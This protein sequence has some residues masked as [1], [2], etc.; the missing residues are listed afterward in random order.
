[1]AVE[2]A[3]WEDALQQFLGYNMRRSLE[4]ARMIR[5]LETSFWGLGGSGIKGSGYTREH[6][7]P[8]GSEGSST[9]VEG[10]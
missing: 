5:N 2:L 10:C 3:S 8:W 7:S 1:M 4:I 6:P 9:I